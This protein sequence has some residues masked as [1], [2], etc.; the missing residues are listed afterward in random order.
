MEITAV[1]ET[2]GEAEEWNTKVPGKE[3]AERTAVK[4]RPAQIVSIVSIQVRTGRIERQGPE[5]AVRR[6]AR[7][8]AVRRAVSSYVRF[9]RK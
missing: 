1:M 8:L 9:L 7:D 6:S 4:L 2:D 5:S 3:K